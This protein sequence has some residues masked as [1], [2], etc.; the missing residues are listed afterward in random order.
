MGAFTG[1]FVFVGDVGRPDL[2]ERAARVHGTME[3]SARQLFR[4]L[5]RFMS[6]PDYLQIWPGHGAGS[7]CGKSLGAVPQSTLG[8]EKRFSWAFGVQEEHDFVSAVL[9]GQPD[10]PRYF[11]AMKRINQ[12]GPRLLGGT[13]RPRLLPVE[14]LPAILANG[15]AVVDTRQARDFALGAVPGT[16]NIPANRAFTTWAGSLLSY[17]QDLYLIADEQ[18]GQTIAELARDLSGIG[19]ERIAGYFGA[20]AVEAWRGTTGQLQ[21]IPALSLNEVT[22]QAGQQGATLLDV[23]NEAEWRAGH[24]PGSVNIPVAYLD[25]RLDEIPRGRII[26]HCQTGPRAAMAASLLRA[27]GF[28]DVSV[29]PGGYTAWQAAGQPQEK[30]E[31]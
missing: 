10:P 31:G 12:E 27:R 21:V 24:P 6:L 28:T 14:A 20:D 30:V 7:A 5:R 9:S 17:D 15:A 1:D 18:R 2:L 25:D 3:E 19:L 22:V 29:F 4:S 13:V 16:I 23:R 26:V 11:A 8:Y